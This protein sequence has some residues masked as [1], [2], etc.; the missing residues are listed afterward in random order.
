MTKNMGKAS[1]S[2]PKT[3][4]NSSTFMYILIICAGALGVTGILRNRI[5]NEK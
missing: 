4:D 2:A 1:S 5:K 3:G